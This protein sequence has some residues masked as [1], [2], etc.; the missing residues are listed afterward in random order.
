MTR[1]VT[2]LLIG[3]GIGLLVAP[4]KGEETR[5]SLAD[6][7]EKWKDKFEKLTNRAAGRLDALRGILGKEITG[8]SEDVRNR[9]LTILDEESEQTASHN[10]H[11]DFKDEF[12]PI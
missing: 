8:L 9:I 2:G 11:Y 4:A 12:R 6:T 3:V 7:A 1:F 10:G 5:A